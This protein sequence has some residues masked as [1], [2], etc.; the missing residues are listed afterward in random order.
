VR[1][2]HRLLDY[3]TEAASQFLRLM[4]A[5]GAHVLSNSDSA[6]GPSGVSPRIYGR[7]ALAPPADIC[8]RAE[9]LANGKSA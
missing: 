4:T 7:F 1:A 3:F 6:A 9:R 8:R 2:R 5:T